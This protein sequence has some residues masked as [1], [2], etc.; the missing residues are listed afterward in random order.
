M[1]GHI[2][3]QQVLNMF[4]LLT[5]QVATLA[6][7]VGNTNANVAA[8]ATTQTTTTQ[9]NKST[10]EKP[11][12][13]EGKDSEGARMFRSVFWL[14][15]QDSQR[16]AND[17]DARR[18]IVSALS[19]MRGEAAVWARPYLETAATVATA[20][21]PRPKVF[22][23]DWD[24]FIEA[25]KAKFEPIDAQMEAKNKILALAQGKRTFAALES[26]FSMWAG[27]TDWSSIDLRDKL[28]ERLTPAYL[29]RMHYLNMPLTTLG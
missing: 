18:L 21:S 28:M 23:D 15:A 8:L 16:F 14:W 13:F 17:T 22:D 29:E 25:F 11:T 19:F 20:T 1:A 4:N 2:T 7:E 10:V 3:E 26:E 12:N 5:A 9:S 24:K 27:R 6:T